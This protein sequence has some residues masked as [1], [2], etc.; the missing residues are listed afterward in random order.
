MMTDDNVKHVGCTRHSR[1]APMRHSISAR[2]VQYGGKRNAAY[3]TQRAIFFRHARAI[4]ERCCASTAGT[5]DTSRLPLN[6]TWVPASAG[7]TFGPV[8]EYP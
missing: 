7:M 1:S 5:H 8:R 3:C 2:S 6:C 4:A